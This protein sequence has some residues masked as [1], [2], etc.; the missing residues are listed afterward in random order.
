VECDVSDP[1]PGGEVVVYALVQLGY[2]D[3][4]VGVTF[5]A[6]LSPDAGVIHLFDSS[7]HYFFLGDSQTGVSVAFG[8]CLPAGPA[9]LVA[10]E[11]HFLRTTGEPC[12]FLLPAAHP[13]LGATYWDCVYTEERL[14]LGD[15]VVLN[16][17]GTCPKALPPYNPGPPDRAADVPLS[18]HLTWDFDAPICEIDI[19]G[20]DDYLYFGT[21]SIPTPPGPPYATVIPPHPIGPL[22]PL[23]TYFWRIRIRAFGHLVDGPVWRFTTTGDIA[24][25]PSTWG[26]IKALY[27]V[28]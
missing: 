17:D 2:T 15:G 7:S 20:E 23:T 6:P 18:T 16:S 3:G 22:Q 28:E 19:S 10:L 26:R 4:A 24:T 13:S 25:Q 21:D 8:S 11:M 5:A 14:V 9:P 27:R 1:G 12:A